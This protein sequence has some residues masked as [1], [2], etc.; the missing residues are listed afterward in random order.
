MPTYHGCTK[1][2]V[3]KNDTLILENGSS[4]IIKVRKKFQVEVLDFSAPLHISTNLKIDNNSIPITHTDTFQFIHYGKTK[5]TWLKSGMENIFRIQVHDVLIQLSDIP[6]FISQ[7][8]D[9]LHPNII[10][11]IDKKLPQKN[12]DE[13]INYIM[14]QDRELNLYRTYINSKKEFIGILPLQV[15]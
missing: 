1:D 3:I 15:K 13:L 5:K 9:S 7:E 6:L 14:L 4:H 2:F 8:I 10:L 11:N 12:I